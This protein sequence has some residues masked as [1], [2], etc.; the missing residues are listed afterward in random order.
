VL[1]NA[2]RGTRRVA[3]LEPPDVPI[4]WHRAIAALLLSGC[5][6][7][8]AAD[9]I[10]TN[11]RVYTL[12][13]APPWAEAVAMRGGRILAVGTSGH[14]ARFAAIGTRTIDLQ[15]AF[16]LP[17]VTSRVPTCWTCTSRTG[18]WSA[19]RERRR[20]EVTVRIN[21]RPQLGEVEHVAAL[22]I[23]GGLV[24]DLVNADHR[25]RVIHAQM[26]HPDDV[27]RFG[28]LRLV[29][30][31]N[32]Y[33]ISDDMRWMEERIGAE[34]SRGAYAFRALSRRS[35]AILRAL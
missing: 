26:V 16:S 24:D 8:E 35:R 7:P 19:S 2:A 3:T 34:R 31:V 4:T 13:E 10:L 9:L 30:E 18:S 25:W 32:P 5:A 29:A 21:L 14:V 11:G 12:D 20:G 1:L 33:H 28:A 23:T 6:A 15:G 27:A 17:G 22:G